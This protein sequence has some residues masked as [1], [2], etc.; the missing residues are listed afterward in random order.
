MG[1]TSAGVKLKT[2]VVKGALSPLTAR[3][4]QL[5]EAKPPFISSTEQTLRVNW[6]HTYLR[7]YGFRRCT[8]KRVHWL[9]LF[10]EA[11]TLRCQFF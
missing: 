2:Q 3:H 6:G 4:R 11:Y 7:W 5:R 8:L 9:P 10:W 1:S